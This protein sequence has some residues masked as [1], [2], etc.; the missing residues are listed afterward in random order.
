MRDIRRGPIWA[1]MAV[2]TAV[3]LAGCAK[4]VQADSTATSR[5][6]L[7]LS[8]K[9]TAQAAEQGSPADEA[10][11]LRS[12]QGMWTNFLAVGKNPD[13]D[14]ALLAQYATGQQLRSNRRW[15]D[16]FERR[17]VVLRGTVDSNP[18]VVALVPNV[19]AVVQDCVDSS[20][21]VEVDEATDKTIPAKGAAA[22]D[23]NIATLEPVHGVW[24]VTKD[25]VVQN[26]C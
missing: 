3:A 19:R 17:G 15:M 26:R 23:L 8:A 22:P 21:W 2:V 20:Q 4:G 16:G 18:R 5:P 6:D 13:G 12:Y 14:S 24:K 10:A 25:T 9:P 1:G 7:S 11:V